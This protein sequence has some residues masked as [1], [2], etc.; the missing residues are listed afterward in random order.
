MLKMREQDCGLEREQVFNS[1]VAVTID[2]EG[3][4]LLLETLR[5]RLQVYTTG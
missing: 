5:H 1:P 3:R 2:G 4:I